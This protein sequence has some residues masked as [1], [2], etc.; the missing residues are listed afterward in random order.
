MW[1]ASS[2][3]ACRCTSTILLAAA[4]KCPG[5][6]VLPPGFSCFLAQPWPLQHGCISYLWIPLGSAS[7]AAPRA[8]TPPVMVI[9]QIWYKVKKQD[10]S[11]R[12]KKVFWA[13]Q[14]TAGLCQATSLHLIIVCCPFSQSQPL[15]LH[16]LGHK[17]PQDIRCASHLLNSRVLIASVT[18]RSSQSC[19]YWQFAQHKHTS[20]YYLTYL[21]RC[22][23]A[24]DKLIEKNAALRS[25]R[26]T[27]SC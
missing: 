16:A 12:K 13:Q 7:C 23:K 3:P 24:W 21:L 9:K 8:E 26:S 20:G 22:N 25:K 27:F 5:R 1:D 15:I 11:H 19:P 10:H 4:N 14:T 18:S 2:R 6:L 17:R